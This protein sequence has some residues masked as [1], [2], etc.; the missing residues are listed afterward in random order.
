MAGG[1]PEHRAVAEPAAHG[2]WP[3]AN[4]GGLAACCASTG[5]LVVCSARPARRAA[6]S[7]E[8]VAHQPPVTRALPTTPARGRSTPVGGRRLRIYFAI[9]LPI[10]AMLAALQN[11]GIAAEVWTRPLAPL[12]CN[13]AVWPHA[14]KAAPSRRWRAMGRRLH[15][16][17]VAAATKRN[18]SPWRWTTWCVARQQVAGSAR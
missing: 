1:W 13:H 12:I 17:A 5:R 15:P 16:R 9:R 2:V 4:A 8:R 11:A 10:R 14:R 18:T 6:L 7:L 3:V